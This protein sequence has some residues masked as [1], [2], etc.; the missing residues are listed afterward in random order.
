MTNFIL[1]TGQWAPIVGTGLA[2]L[3]SLYVLLVKDFIFE[4]RRQDKKKQ[5]EKYP[6][7]GK[8]KKTSS[9][10]EY[11]CD[12]SRTQTVP[13]SLTID[14]FTCRKCGGA[15]TTSDQSK[16]QSQG[17]KVMQALAN[18]R[19]RG[20]RAMIVIFEYIGTAPD[21]TFENSGFKHAKERWIQY[22]GEKFKNP[23]LSLTV[24][25]FRRS[26][27][28]SRTSDPP[29]SMSGGIESRRDMETASARSLQ[30]QD[31]APSPRSLSLLGRLDTA[32]TASNSTFP[33][34][35]TYPEVPLRRG[36]SETLQVPSLPS[37]I[38]RPPTRES[39]APASPTSELVIVRGGRD[40]PSLVVPHDGEI[41][42]SS[43]QTRLTRS[44]TR[45]LPSPRLSRLWQFR[46][47]G[48][49]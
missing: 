42:L 11:D 10:A 15:S 8:Q 1:P 21:H 31:S 22:P 32:T 41:L 28:F 46:R 14:N 16:G 17:Q 18:W 30:S 25:Q 36:T 44:E 6:G 20:G 34:G 37:P 5:E 27:E 38:H 29:L 4:K 26:R 23:A 43:R 35:E 12:R 7:R 40:T 39:L 3:G 48:S 45:P 2:L 24:D 47:H 33:S 13:P 49:L 9:S 19:R